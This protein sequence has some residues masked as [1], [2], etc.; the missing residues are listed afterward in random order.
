MRRRHRDRC[1]FP[2]G[3]LKVSKKIKISHVFLSHV[4]KKCPLESQFEK[5]DF[6]REYFW[7]KCSH[8]SLYESVLPSWPIISQNQSLFFGINK[9]SETLTNVFFMLDRFGRKMKPMEKKLFW[10][11]VGYFRSIFQRNYFAGVTKMPHNWAEILGD[12]HFQHKIIV[13]APIVN[14][15]LQTARTRLSTFTNEI[16]FQKSIAPD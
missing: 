7:S 4:N 12:A 14:V 8:I 6:N 16:S 11:N 9:L 2:C 3:R 15:I 1:I 13:L 5:S 10:I